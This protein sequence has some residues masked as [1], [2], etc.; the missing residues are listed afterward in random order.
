M[1]TKTQAVPLQTPFNPAQVEILKIF[2]EGLTE[3][4]IEELRQVLLEFRLKLLDDHI[5]A[6]AEQKKLTV[7]QINKASKE[8]RR[9]PY[10]GKE[11]L[12][13]K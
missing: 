12:A 9:T 13:S 1:S 8:H 6:I 7:E 3:A 2:S 10:H 11:R 5:E 4:Q